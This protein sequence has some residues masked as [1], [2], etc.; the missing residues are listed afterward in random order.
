MPTLKKRFRYLLATVRGALFLF[1]SFGMFPFVIGVIA[2]GQ[3]I[4]EGPME[5]FRIGQTDVPKWLGAGATNLGICVFCL[6]V[7]IALA[8]CIV[9]RYLQHRETLDFLRGRG[10]DDFD[11]DGKVDS[12]ADSFLDDL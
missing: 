10:I 11:R 8:V 2:L 12:F 4:S 9:L 5:S 3:T 6:V 7:L 1:V